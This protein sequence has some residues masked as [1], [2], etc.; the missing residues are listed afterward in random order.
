MKLLAERN[1]QITGTIIYLKLFKLYK[2]YLL[3]ISDQENMGIGN[4]TLG[5][6]PIIDGI[7]PPTASY[8]LFGVGSKLLSTIIVEKVSKILNAP[9]LLLLFLKSIV[10]EEKIIKPLAN[11]LNEV[12]DEINN[13]K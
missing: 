8:N 7:K 1:I 3:L 9:V 11:L 13:R 4:V 6:P 12:L 5:S 10:E 2:S